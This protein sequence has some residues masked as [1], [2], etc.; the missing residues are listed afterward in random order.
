MER[1]WEGVNE[2]GGRVS[3]FEGVKRREGRERKERGRVGG[4][5]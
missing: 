5:E 4:R 2:G 3:D 1:K